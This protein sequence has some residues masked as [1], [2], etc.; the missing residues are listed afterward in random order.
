MAPLQHFSVE[1]ISFFKFHYTVAGLLPAKHVNVESVMTKGN[2]LRERKCITH[3]LNCFKFPLLNSV[4][5]FNTMKSLSN[6]L[7]GS[8]AHEANDFKR[9][10]TEHRHGFKST[11]FLSE[12][13][14]AYRFFKT[15]PLVPPNL[16]MVSEKAHK[17]N[18]VWRSCCDRYSDE[19]RVVSQLSALCG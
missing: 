6:Q 4:F 15:L 2:Q 10:V 13:F 9:L 14:K 1:L 12:L 19:I 16:L 11:R 3:K 17:T 18:Q 8:S 5:F 7:N